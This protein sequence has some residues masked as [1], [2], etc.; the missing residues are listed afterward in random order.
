MNERRITEHKSLRIVLQCGGGVVSR[1]IH[2]QF[3]WNRFSQKTSHSMRRSLKQ[4]VLFN[5]IWGTFSCRSRNPKMIYHTQLRSRVGN[6][7]KITE[8]CI[9][10]C[11]FL[12]RH[13]LFK[14][15]KKK[16]KIM[17][18]R[19]FFSCGEVQ[20]LEL[21]ETSWAIWKANNRAAHS[22][23]S[24]VRRADAKARL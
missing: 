7:E 23:V 18:H 22:T 6:K 17:D 24:V 5:S 14:G 13:F 15:G 10:E 4:L 21:Q 1:R 8:E 20:V 2:K 12:K 16:K 11:L 3:S 9:T 19:G